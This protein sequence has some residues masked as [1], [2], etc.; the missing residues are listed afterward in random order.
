MTCIYS[1]IDQVTHK[2]R[3]LYFLDAPG[4]TEK[5]F[6][7]NLV[8][9]K[10][11]QKK[12]ISLAVVSSGITVTLLPGSRT[13][14]ATF[15]LPFNLTSNDKPVCNISKSSSL[16]HVLMKCSLIIWDEDTMSH[17]RSVE[18]INRML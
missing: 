8:L 18:T 15:T 16:A 9:A 4:G 14:H 6:V 13:T 1:I 11:W 3:R 5:T 17:N 10:V 7:T 12:E 2:R